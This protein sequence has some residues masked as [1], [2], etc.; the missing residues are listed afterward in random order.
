[1]SSTKMPMSTSY[2]AV[3]ALSILMIFV[4]IIGGTMSGSKSVGFGVWYWGYTA[5]KMYKRDNN[6]LVFLQKIMLWFEVAAFSVALAVLL[7]SDSD[8]RRYVNVTPL[9]FIILASLSISVTYF[10]YKFFKKQQSGL[11]SAS[12][13]SNSSIEDMFWEQASRELESDRHEAT[14][15]RAMASAEGND[16][17]TKALYIKIRSFDLQRTSGSTNFNNKN[18]T[19]GDSGAIK[20]QLRLFWSSFNPIGKFAIAAIVALIFY[21]F[22]DFYGNSDSDNAARTT[23]TALSKKT[24]SASA[25][26]ATQE[27]CIFVWNDIQRNFVKVKDDIYDSNKYA[28]TI[29]IK[30][31]KEDYAK[32]LFAQLRKADAENNVSLAESIAKEVRANALTVYYEKKLTSDYINL[33]ATE[34]NLRSRCL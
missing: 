13:F 9:E 23:S 33:L 28:D 2:K 14:W 22:Y 31:G 7:F 4:V 1:M 20:G 5:W 21:A 34:H 12:F 19:I 27:N 24:E 3:F 10:L 8:V 30:L 16:A 15:A 18:S 25:N 32:S 29:I 6:S 11:T 17:K 26:K